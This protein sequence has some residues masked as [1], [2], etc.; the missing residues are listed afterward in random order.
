[1]HPAR[2]EPFGL[3]VL[4]AAL[5]GCA[6]V[7]GDLESLRER[8]DGAAVF[9]PPWDDDALLDA[10]AALAGDEPRRRGLGVAARERG[11]AFTPR[12]MAQGY[13]AIYTALVRG[14]APGGAR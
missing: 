10:I 5:S 9:V 3:A 14:E 8:W 11:L 7:L 12:R 6:L 4:E 13:R 1:M 2:Y